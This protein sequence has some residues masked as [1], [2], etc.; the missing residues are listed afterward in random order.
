LRNTATGIHIHLIKDVIWV[1][2]GHVELFVVGRGVLVEVFMLLLAQFSFVLFVVVIVVLVD[3]LCCCWHNIFFDSLYIDH[4]IYRD[5]CYKMR[6]FMHQLSVNQLKLGMKVVKLDKNWLDTPFLMHSFIIKSEKSLLQLRQTCKHVFV[7]DNPSIALNNIIKKPKF[8]KLLDNSKDRLEIKGVEVIKTSFNL[9]NLIFDSL[10]SSAYLNSFKVK[11]ISTTIDTYTATPDDDVDGDVEEGRSVIGGAAE[12]AYLHRLGRDGVLVECRERT[13]HKYGRVG[14]RQVPGRPEGDRVSPSLGGAMYPFTLRPVERQ[15]FPVHRKE[16]LTKELPQG[17]KHI[18]EPPDHRIVPADRIAGLGDVDHEQDSDD[19]GT[20][21]HGEDE[22]R[23]QP[24]DPGERH[25]A[26]QGNF[27]HQHYLSFCF[28][29]GFPGGG[30]VT[31]VHSPRY[32]RRAT[33]ASSI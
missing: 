1:W 26:D 31:D 10:T 5:V 30:T 9:L 7:E 19:Q 33:P 20:Q 15:F 22:Q 24:A 18:A 3:V 2:I 13:I 27:F 12:R 28:S 11:E 23:G 17:H 29:G 32:A 8:P 14:R 6:Y 25:L 16:I 4:T 21:P